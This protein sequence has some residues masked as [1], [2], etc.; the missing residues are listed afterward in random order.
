[1][2]TY[3][4]IRPAPRAKPKEH[5][6]LTDALDKAQDIA[7]T[8]PEYKPAGT[9]VAVPSV[10]RKVSLTPQRPVL[11][12]ARVLDHVRTILAYWA[13]WDTE[14]QLNVA[15]LWVAS[16]WFTNNDGQ[17]A[18]T[19]HP[20]LFFI[21]PPTS[22]KTRAMKL[23][24]SM[25]K[26]PTGIVK[27][28]VTAPGVRDAL[29]AGRT[30]FLDEIDRQIGKGGGHLDI[31]SLI[32]AYEADTASLNGRGGY[33]EE[34]IFGAMALGAKPRILTG[35]NGYIE[36][37]F[38]RSFI[39]TP[40]KSGEVIPRLDEK[41]EMAVEYMPRVL[42]IWAE[43]VRT[44]MEG[45]HL[46]P[47]HDVPE[48]LE[49]R[50]REISEPLLAV[51]DRAVDPDVLAAEGADTRWAVIGREAVQGMLLGHGSDGAD[52][53]ADITGRLQALGMDIM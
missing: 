46:W 47:I 43:A 38:E 48:S 35:T 18:F 10:I 11:N 49:D 34:S 2:I 31:Q 51:A 32:S 42:E 41:F 17:L 53:L 29:R 9:A 23:I 50:Q 26:D 16:T 14:H 52:I 27:A 36:D 15:T 13:R 1:M 30:V 22:G 6:T 3:Q 4:A 12:T 45:K 7:R 25:S 24:R 20:R 28:P 19:A 37:L 8:D 33:N 40:H 5:M 44:D 21:A 39:M